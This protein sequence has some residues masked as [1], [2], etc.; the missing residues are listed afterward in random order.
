MDYAGFAVS[1]SGRAQWSDQLE[2]RETRKVVPTF[3]GIEA[4]KNWPRLMLHLRLLVLWGGH[5]RTEDSE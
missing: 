1:G 3:G 5:W 2:T 4:R